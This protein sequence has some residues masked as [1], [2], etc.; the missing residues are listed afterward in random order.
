MTTEGHPPDLPRYPGPE[1]LASQVAGEAVAIRGL[2]KA[3]GGRTVVDH[4]D[5]DVP[6]GSF[7]GLVGPNGAGKTTTLSMVTGLL[8]PDAGRVFVAGADV[9]ADPVGAKSRMGVLPDGLRLFERLSGAELLSYLGRLRGLPIDVV[10]SRAQELITVLDLADAGNKLV[11]DYST[12]MRKK[13]TLA[14]AMLHAP[15]VLLLDEPLEAVDPVSAR[16][17]RTVLGAVHRRWRHRRLLLPRD[18][19]GR[20]AVQSRCRDRGRAHRR[21]RR[22]GVRARLG[23]IP[24]RRLHAPGGRR[25]GRRGGP[26]VVGVFA[27]L[28]WTLVTSRLRNASG[29]S[30]GGILVGMVVALIVLVLAAVALG[31]LRNEPEIARRVV[32]SLFA[33]QL[34]AWML[35]PL[36]AFGIDETVDPSRFALLPLRPRTLQ[37]GLLVSSLIGYL[38]A[39][40]A[41]LLIGAAVAISTPWAVLPLALVAAALQLVL[42]VVLSRAASTSMAALMTSRRGR[43]LGMLVGLALV[44]GYIGFS[45]LL[46]SGADSTVVTGALAVAD[47]LEWTPPGALAAL[48]G[49]VADGNWTRVVIAA[50]IVAVGFALAWWWWGAALRR[51]LTHG[52]SVTEGSTPAGRASSGTAVGGSVVGTAEVVGNRDRVLMWRDPMRRMPWLLLLVLI[53]AWPF[54]VAKGPGGVYAVVLG[55]LLIGAQAANMFSVEGSGL[56]LHL[57]TIAD[58]SRAR[59]EIAGHIL[60]ALVP[61]VVIVLIAT[62]VQVVVHDA[63]DHAPAALGISLTAMLGSFAGAS[64]QSALLPYAMPQSR[65]SM[66]ASSVPGQKGR[67]F[68]ASLVVLLSGVPV[69]LPAVALALVAGSTGDAVWGWLGL[70]VG[71]ACGA[72]AIAWAVP[73]AARRYLDSGPE[74]LATVRAG[75]RL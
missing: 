3:F 39:A 58:R 66:F 19:A 55:A 4:I 51:S 11:A 72:T 25:R 42:C 16:I 38:P 44:I 10:T 24:G 15:A 36:V 67:T 20:G 52:T 47:A 17:I 13:I 34:V 2:T 32:V 62:A 23:R 70:V 35:A 50:A 60:A 29:N 54:L 48:P 40:N 18:G 30:R 8:R 26:V 22:P 6:A 31:F 74:L 28:K 68:V 27:S 33:L 59:G 73:F 56:W 43:D 49:Y 65:S 5:L 75:D 71:L 9:W 37:A 46:N 7:F 14:A 12:G 63:Y 57:Q 21:V 1:Q 69:A 64:V 61:G 53:I 41:I 45:F